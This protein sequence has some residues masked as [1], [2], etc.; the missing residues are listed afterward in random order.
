MSDLTPDEEARCQ[1][2]HAGLNALANEW[3]NKNNLAADVLKICHSPQAID[4]YTRLAFAEG[5][6]EGACRQADLMR[7]KAHD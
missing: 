5:V 2:T 4:N 6:Y 3:A 7:S 1:K